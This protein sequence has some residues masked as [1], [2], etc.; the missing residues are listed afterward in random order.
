MT[1]SATMKA[2]LFAQETDEVFLFL[3]TLEHEDLDPT[4]YLVDNTK[5]ITSNGTVFT[6]FPFRAILPMNDPQQ[7]PRA[8]IEIDN[9]DRQIVTAIRSITGPPSISLEIIRAAAPDV[10]EISLKDFV[11]TDVRYNKLTV[12][13]TL[14]YENFL[15]E[16]YPGDDFVPSTFPGIF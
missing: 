13:G 3:L 9:V 2:A 12:T 15:Q 7:P 16:P 10:I 4:I 1:I 14:S 8:T 11:M 5:D 6:A